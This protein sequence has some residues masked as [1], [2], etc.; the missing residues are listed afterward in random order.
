MK[1]A[2]GLM[3]ITIGIAHIYMYLRYLS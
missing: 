1:H 2:F 3:L